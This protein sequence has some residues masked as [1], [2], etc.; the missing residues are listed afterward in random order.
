MSEVKLK[1]KHAYEVKS[2]KEKSAHLPLSEMDEREKSE[3]NSEVAD[4]F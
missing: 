1:K 3:L 4:V 2:S